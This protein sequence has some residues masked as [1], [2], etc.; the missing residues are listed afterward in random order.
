MSKLESYKI[1]INGKGI[2]AIGHQVM[3]PCF[4]LERPNHDVVYYPW[5]RLEH[6]RVDSKAIVLA[7]KRAQEMQEAERSQIEIPRGVVLPSD[8][9]A[10]R[11]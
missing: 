5:D 8:P 6:V 7:E 4:V 9:N 2:D 11:N 1:F 10:A 3:V